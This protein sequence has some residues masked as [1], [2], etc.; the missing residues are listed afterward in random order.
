MAVSFSCKCGER[1]KPIKE[2]NW[3]VTKYRCNYSAFSGY[4][5]TPS[6][7]STVVCHAPG[8]SACGRTKAK[9][10]DELVALGKVRDGA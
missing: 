10:V 6:E 2:R 3:E 8:C 1:K 9:F 5:Y 4:H 7:Y